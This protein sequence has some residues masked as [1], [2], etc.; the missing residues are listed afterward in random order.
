MRDQLLAGL[1]PG[2][3]LRGDE[4]D[5]PVRVRLALELEI[6]T[7]VHFAD[8]KALLGRVVLDDE[9]LQE[10]EGAL[11][12]DAL[13]DLDLR[14]PEMG[15]VGLLAV[16]ALQVHDDELNHETLLQEGPV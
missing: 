4:V 1:E 13:S 14:H 8:V 15:S 10:E 9:L 3:H 2:R 12:V 7:V 11:V 6:E 16:V 5:E